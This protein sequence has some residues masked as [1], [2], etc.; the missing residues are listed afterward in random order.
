MEVFFLY[1]ES[2]SVYIITFQHYRLS[3]FLFPSTG[4]VH[5]IAWHAAE[6]VHERRVELQAQHAGPPSRHLF[7]TTDEPQ[8]ADCLAFSHDGPADTEMSTQFYTGHKYPGVHIELT[9]TA[10]SATETSW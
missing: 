2:S 3:L 6:S 7:S 4:K 10:A 9:A 8:L 1:P 5:R